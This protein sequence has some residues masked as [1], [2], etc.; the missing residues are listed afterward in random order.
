MSSRIWRNLNENFVIG[1]VEIPLE[2]GYSYSAHTRGFYISS[3]IHSYILPAYSLW[4]RSNV[5]DA[6]G[7]HARHSILFFRFHLG[8]SWRGALYKRFL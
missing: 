1:A 2:S 7:N 3:T 5:G 4:H 8:A 6:A